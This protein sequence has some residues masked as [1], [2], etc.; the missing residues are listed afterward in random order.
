[1]AASIHQPAE[2]S[3]RFRQQKLTLK[4]GTRGNSDF[5]AEYRSALNVLMLATGLGLLIARANPANLLLARS[6]Q[7]RK[8]FAIRAAMGAGR[9]ELMAQF[10]TEALLLAA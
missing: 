2:Q 8:E 1:M 7:R 3:P 5:R 4:D 10:L 9:G 6:A